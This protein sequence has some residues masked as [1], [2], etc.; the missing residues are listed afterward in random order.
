AERVGEELAGAAE[1]REE[2]GGAGMVGEEAEERRALALAGQTLHVVERHVRVGRGG[3]LG[4]EPGQRRAEQLGVAGLGGDGVQVHEGRRRVGPA[5]RGEG[6]PGAGVARRGAQE[7]GRRRAA[8]P[9]GRRGRGAAAA[10]RCQIADSPV[11]PVRMRMAS[12][13]GRTKTLPSPM[14][15]VLAAPQMT[16]TT[17]SAIWSVTT[18]STLTLGRKSM[19]YSEPR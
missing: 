10:R 4:E 13:I 11:S 14:D 17:L 3:E 6:A 12:P 19:V 8:R 1:A 18:T 5:Q 9:A 2:V 16:D 15:P 7:I